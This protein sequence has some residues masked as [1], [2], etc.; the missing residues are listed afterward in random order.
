MPSQDPAAQVHQLLDGLL[1]QLVQQ[2]QQCAYQAG[3]QHGLNQALSAVRDCRDSYL[4]A[5]GPQ[6][7]LEHHEF[8]L[9]GLDDAA[10]TLQQ[11]GAQL[12][13]T[14]TSSD[15]TTCSDID[16]DSDGM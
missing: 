15:T 16:D 4:A 5:M 13:D 12:S 14:T 7:E 2:T 1:D 11:L 10:L 3:Q 6:A 8:Y 9:D